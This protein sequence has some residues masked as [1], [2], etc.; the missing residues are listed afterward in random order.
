LATARRKSMEEVVRIRQQN[1]LDQQRLYRKLCG[2]CKGALP[3]S[4][5]VEEQETG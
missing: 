5:L 1:T 2:T 4:P 3:S